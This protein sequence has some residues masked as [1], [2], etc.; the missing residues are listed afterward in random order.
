[1]RYWSFVDFFKNYLLSF[2]GLY[3]IQK[4]GI[5]AEVKTGKRLLIEYLIALLS[6]YKMD[7]VEGK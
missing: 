3:V 1:M 5:S 4:L 6:K 2:Y 7:S